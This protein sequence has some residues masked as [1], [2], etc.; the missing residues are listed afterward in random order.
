MS[1]TK[2]VKLS[3]KGQIV[4]PRQVREK[5]QIKPGENLVIS[6]INGQAVLLKPLQY[7]EKT[8]G[9]IRGTWGRAKTEADRYIKVERD[10]WE[11]KN[12]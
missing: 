11:K 1:L 4:V 5:L 7:A 9:L 10:S 6:V 12:S 8:A 3:Q 2:I